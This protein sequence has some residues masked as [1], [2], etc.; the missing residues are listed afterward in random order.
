[1]TALLS[2]H[3]PERD[4]LLRYA[5]LLAWIMQSKDDRREVEETAVHV[6]RVELTIEQHEQL[7][8][9][10]PDELRDE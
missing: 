1:M 7:N 9:F 2:P 6:W 4:E 3:E 8:R 5:A 10:L